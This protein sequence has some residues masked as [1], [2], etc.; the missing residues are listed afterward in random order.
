MRKL[1]AL[2]HKYIHDLGNY[3]LLSSVTTFKFAW[4]Y[5]TKQEFKAYIEDLRRRKIELEAIRALLPS[6]ML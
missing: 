4:E 5:Y 3:K 2:Q 1:I 6:D